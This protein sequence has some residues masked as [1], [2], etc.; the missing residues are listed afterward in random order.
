M[1]FYVDAIEPHARPT[2]RTLT[3]HAGDQVDLWAL[4]HDPDGPRGLRRTV[5]RHP[6]EGPPRGASKVATFSADDHGLAALSAGREVHAELIRTDHRSRLVGGMRLPP[7][8]TLE[9]ALP[10]GSRV[11][12]T[13]SVRRQVA[14]GAD[15][16]VGGGGTR[17]SRVV[18][19]TDNI[20]WIITDGKG[21]AVTV[22]INLWDKTR[23][24]LMALGID[25]RV[26]TFMSG[27]LLSAL[28]GA[29]ISYTQYQRAEAQTERADTVTTALERAEAAQQASLATELACLDQRKELV[30][31]LGQV[32]ARR[33]LAAE[34]ALGFALSNTIAVQ[35]G[36][37]RLAEPRLLQ[38]DGLLNPTLVDEVVE[39]LQAPATT[40]EPCEAQSTA[41]STDLPPYLLFYH[42]DPALTCPIDYAVVDEGVDR[43]GRFGLS[44]R[45]ARE[46]RR[47]GDESTGAPVGTL[48]ELLGDPR[49]EDRWAAYTLA[50]AY[51]E[52][53]S[54]LLTG[55]RTERPPVLPSQAQVW[56][57]TLLDAYNQLP[58][59]PGGALDASMETCIQRLLTHRVDTAP[60]AAPG[61]PV[62]PDI[63]SVARGEEVFAAPPTPG[64]PWPRD[65]MATSAATALNTVSRLAAVQ[66]ER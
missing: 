28:A 24:R 18:Y 5:F 57:L 45:I 61:D 9:L 32:E 25:S 58:S 40:T 31:E 8:A 27:I 6:D 55:V 30:A 62:L 52:T 54:L 42:P 39:R 19:N 2:R 21:L 46:F 64:C 34:M 14:S 66:L 53:S 12:L 4:P 22:T 33:G 20:W 36:G 41:L 56:G 63:T 37:D 43:A 3:L 29:Y 51:R 10:D 26:L 59:T 49:L 23:D 1:S 17:R 38:A 16:T 50:T 47:A 13:L 48:E 11:D 60:P 44:K 15:L 65:V 7:V 35:Y